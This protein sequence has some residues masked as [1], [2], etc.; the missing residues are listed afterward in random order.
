[1]PEFDL[2]IR[3]TTQ[4]E[5]RKLAAQQRFGTY[6]ERPTCFDC[7]A[8]VKRKPGHTAPLFRMP[9]H[10]DHIVPVSRGGTSNVANL[11]ATCGTCNMAKGADYGREPETRRH[12]G[13]PGHT[14]EHRV[15]D[16]AG[17]TQV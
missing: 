1:M 3:S 10:V 11:Q 4:R 6:A 5:R 9:V 8:T 13:D 15:G 17:A 16:R 14:G 12:S 7:G 2:W